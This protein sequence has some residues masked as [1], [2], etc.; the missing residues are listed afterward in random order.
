M[1][2]PHEY[3]KSQQ[4][5]FK[6]RF[7]ELLKKKSISTDPAFKADVKDAAEWITTRMEAIGLSAELI[8]L[9]EGR[10]PIVLGSWDDAGD[11]AKTV[12]VYC[13]YD[14]QPAVIEDG[15]H[16][17]PF[18]PIIKDG[19]LFCRGAT[20][21]KVHVM[22]W[23]SAVES[24]VKTDGLSVNIKLLFEGEEESGSET[25][26]AFIQQF[27]EKVSSDIAVISDGIIRSPEQPALIY[28]LRGIITL[29][30][31]IDGPHRDLH[32]GHFGGTVHN[33]AQVIAEIVSQLHDE[34]GRVT[35]PRFY[36]DVLD[37]DA[38]ERALLAESDASIAE[39]W[40]TVANAPKQWGESDFSLHE[41]IGARPTLEIN[42][43]HGG[44]TGEG[45]KTVL[46]AHAFAKISCR[47]VPN[48]EP[49]KIMD[50]VQNY[51][52]EIAP[53]TVTVSFVN[54]EAEAPAIKI[55]YNG[56]AMQ[57]AYRAYERGWGV[58][59]VF[60]RAGGSVPIT[61]DMLRVSDNLAIMGFS[62]KGGGAHGPDE[63]IPLS[64]F[65]KGI[66]T[67]IY[68]LQDIAQVKGT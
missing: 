19:K 11:D 39:E 10:H 48:Q 45:F 55:D 29:E 33:P 27:P 1:A 16:S 50:A 46:P 30:V 49:E 34:N 21:S 22:A 67:A 61:H 40:S 8:S 18:E 7:I 13:H 25:I 31:H 36:D 56:E 15:W 52:R 28:G 59:P 47:L 65:Y 64:M 57:A 51:I 26:G 38:E 37:L 41:R 54:V 23:L 24:L 53:D 4:E 9:P 68:F 5:I 42:G 17:E 20:D 32:S 66:D 12:L 58:K 62:Y 63:N 14:V 6:S 35:V 2:N 60:E 3:A 44:Y 43:I